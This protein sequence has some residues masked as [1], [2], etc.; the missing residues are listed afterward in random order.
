MIFISG[1]KKLVWCSELAKVIQLTENREMHGI[2]CKISFPPPDILYTK[3]CFLN[4][5]KFTKKT[6]KEVRYLLYKI[7]GTFFEKTNSHNDFI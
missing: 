4:M 7:N 6:T 3:S 2:S 5:I 1:I